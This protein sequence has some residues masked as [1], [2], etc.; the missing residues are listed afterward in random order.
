MD[1]PYLYDVQMNFR[2]QP[3]FQIKKS[4]NPESGK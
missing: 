3:E 2:L 4:L 1:N